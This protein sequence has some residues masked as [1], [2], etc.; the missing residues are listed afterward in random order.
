MYESR[1]EPP[2]LRI[3]HDM[4]RAEQRAD[5]YLRRPA[6]AVRLVLLDGLFHLRFRRQVAVRLYP[7]C[8]AFR[9]R[10]S[11]PNV[12]L[13]RSGAARRPS[14][15]ARRDRPGSQVQAGGSWAW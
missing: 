1:R 15:V 13:S 3:F 14:C 2:S 12:C 9:R 6:R 4:D 5:G 7:H 11:S 8:Q 10:Q